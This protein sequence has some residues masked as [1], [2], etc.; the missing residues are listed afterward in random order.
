MA[1]ELKCSY[2]TISSKELMT[3]V[4]PDYCIESPVDC[5]F[6]ERGSN[7]TYLLRSVDA[8]YSLRIYRHENYPRDEIDFEVDALNYLHN[9]GFPVAFPIPRKSGGYVTEITAPEG[10]RYVLVTAFVEG[11]SP[12]YESLDDF[13]L[14]GESVARLH[15][16]SEGFTTPHKKKDLDFKNFAE[17]SLK[18]IEPSLAHRPE[19]LETLKKY[20]ET[21][22]SSI[23][24]VGED[25]PDTGFCHGDV[26]G[27][28]AHLHQGVLTHFD[29]EECGFGYRVFDLATFKWSLAS[30]A[31]GPERWASFVQGYESVRKISEADI[32]LVDTFVLLRHIWLIAFHMRNAHDFGGE[33]TSDEY[34][35]QQWR[36]LKR[37]STVGI[38]VELKTEEEHTVV[39]RVVDGGSAAISK[40]MSAGDRILGVGNDKNS[41]IVDTLNWSLNDVVDLIAG[42]KGTTVRLKILPAN[43]PAKSSPKIVALVRDKV[44]L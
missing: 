28:N 9:N 31:S 37:L 30:G 38:G 23:Q 39:V 3:K 5:L 8:R 24:N 43:A 17:D 35:D 25:A 41:E 32:E 1:I 2:S 4:I 44:R 33:F 40:Q 13:R 16:A 26:H 6:W 14:T 29:F 36:R 18:T 27:F 19:D 12:E 11:T 7:D 10:L 42:Q 21:C 15:Q 22:R 34:I 20:I